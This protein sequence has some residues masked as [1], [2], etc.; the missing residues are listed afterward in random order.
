MEQSERLQKIYEYSAEK[1]T[2]PP[3]EHFNYDMHKAAIEKYA[4]LPRWEK[5]AR[6]TADAIVN[7]DI[8]IEPFDKIIGRT[9]Y[10]GIPVEKGDPDF[11]FRALA[12][13]KTDAQMPFIR[14][15]CRQKVITLTGTHTGT[16]YN[17]F[18]LPIPCGKFF[19]HADKILI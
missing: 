15:K 1:G 8:I 18:D 3:Q 19:I 4:D 16:L 13:E 17:T 7:Q 14:L 6:S 11:D 9:Y 2:N 5:I 12:W 10:N